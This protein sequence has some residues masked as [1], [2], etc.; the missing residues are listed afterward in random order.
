VIGSVV[1]YIVDCVLLKGGLLSFD[2]FLLSMFDNVVVTSL[3]N[4]FVVNV[5]WN[6]VVDI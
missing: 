1:G 2:Y 6:V 5:I 4:L 3:C